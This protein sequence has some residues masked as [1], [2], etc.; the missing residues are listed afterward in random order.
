MK[1]QLLALAT[2]ILGTCSSNKI[3]TPADFQPGDERVSSAGVSVSQIVAPHR[4]LASYPLLRLA[5]GEIKTMKPN[6]QAVD[7]SGTAV[8]AENRIV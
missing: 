1:I 4:G 3:E 5:N 8:T 7:G 2:A 6:M